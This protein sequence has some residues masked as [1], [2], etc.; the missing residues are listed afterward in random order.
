SIAN[1]PDWKV[2]WAGFA[3]GARYTGLVP[4]LSIWGDLPI[5]GKQPLHPIITRSYLIKRHIE[6]IRSGGDLVAG[7]LPNDSR[8]WRAPRYP[9]LDTTEEMDFGRLV[10][11]RVSAALVQPSLNVF[12][13]ED[14]ALDYYVVNDESRALRPTRLEFSYGGETAT[15]TIP[16][17]SP[18][19]LHHGRIVLHLPES[20]PT[21]RHVLRLFL[22]RRDRLVT[23]NFYYMHVG[24]RPDPLTTSKR[25]CIWLPNAA[26]QESPT[27]EVLRS[28][29][30]SPV[31]TTTGELQRL[32][33]S[34]DLLV[35]PSMWGL[36]GDWTTVSPQ[37]NEVAAPAIRRF[38]EAGGTVL[39]L[40][41]SVTG[42][43]PWVPEWE[44]VDRGPNDV[45]DPALTGH[46]LYEGLDRLNW[47][48]L[49]GN[50]CRITQVVMSPLTPNVVGG[51]CSHADDLVYMAIAE[52]QVG[53]GHLIHS[54]V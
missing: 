4:F 54:Q 27:V 49:N 53:E 20:C 31:A 29:G 2:S 35:V 17:L 40:E 8:P 13:G 14:V 7:M 43:I 9:V 6:L 28:L 48:W 16:E 44:L 36:Q 21:G 34:R 52:A 5:Q 46:P 41:Q 30:L 22:R 3:N 39:C 1:P 11:A 12:R 24:L 15:A 25:V 45:I 18:A 51:V 10:F 19:Q 37:A 26:A 42:P 47:L 32:R 38:L 50:N 23:E 33:P